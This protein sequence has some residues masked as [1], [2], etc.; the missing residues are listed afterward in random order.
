MLAEIYESIDAIDLATS[1]GE[2]FISSHQVILGGFE[3]AK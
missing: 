1:F 3:K 2:K